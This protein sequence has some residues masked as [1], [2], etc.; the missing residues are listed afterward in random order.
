MSEPTV[1]PLW[2]GPAPQSHGNE[3][4]DI[5][6]ITAYLPKN[7][8]HPA[9]AMIVCPGGGYNILMMDYEGSNV[10]EWF[11]ERGIAGFVLKY[12]LPA[13]GYHH[14]VPLLDAQR[15]IRLV[16]H[17]AAEWNI[18]ASQVGIMGFSAGGHLAASATA[19]FDGG[20][21]TATDLVDRE[22]C[23]PDFAVLV[24]PVIT[25]TDPHGDS[26]TRKNIIGPDANPALVD[27]LSI[28]KQ[29]TAKTP[30][31]LLVHAADDGPVPIENSRLMLA[32]LQQAGV[33][34]MMHEYPTGGHGFGYYLDQEKNKVT[35]WLDRTHDWL[36]RNGLVT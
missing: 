16:R 25:M 34:S 3:P 14:P 35:G 7:A 18:D 13:K 8:R 6:S 19:H 36:K 31:V 1:T 10:A 29:V 28:E 32:A 27:H 12:R 24:Y 26:G 2:N 15:A 22:S 5:P 33:L 21:R 11:Q 23:R 30:P 4:Q 20:H 17:N 9:P